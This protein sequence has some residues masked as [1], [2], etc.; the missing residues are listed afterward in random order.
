MMRLMLLLVWVGGVRLQGL[1]M[2]GGICSLP[3][4]S[5]IPLLVSCT[6]SW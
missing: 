2:L 1:L 5:G 3:E 4:I 6:G